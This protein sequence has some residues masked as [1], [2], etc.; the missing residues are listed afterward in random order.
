M[1]DDILEFC[2]ECG[3]E[4]PFGFEEICSLCGNEVEI[5]TDPVDELPFVVGTEIDESERCAVC[6]KWYDD[7][8]E[9]FWNYWTDFDD[10]DWLSIDDVWCFDCIL[11]RFKK[12][13][14]DFEASGLEPDTYLIWKE[15][16]DVGIDLGPKLFDIEMS[17]A[18]RRMRDIDRESMVQ[19]LDSGCEVDEAIEWMYLFDDFDEAVAWRDAGFQPDEYTT[20]R[21]HDWGC[22]PAEASSFLSQGLEDAPGKKYRDFG[23]TLQDAVFLELNGFTDYSDGDTFIGLWTS[24]G[25]SPVQMSKLKDELLEEES[26]FSELHETSE[27]HKNIG[28]RTYS[29]WKSLPGMF[30]ALKG[31]GLPITIDNLK[32]FWGLSD[33]QILK[34]IDAGGEVEHRANIV[35]QGVAVEKTSLVERLLDA[36]VDERVAASVS[37]KGLML[38]H[39]KKFKSREDIRSSVLR[40]HDIFNSNFTMDINE[41]LLWLDTGGN[42]TI[43]KQWRDYGID[44]ETASKWQKQGFYAFTAKQWMDA[45]VTSPITA[46]NRRDAGIQ[47]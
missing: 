22:T 10:P 33:K 8:D 7:E 15:A 30:E 37:R 36:G 2:K 31:V 41:A 45:G 20:G 34:V 43:V 19:W 38:K 21:W 25:L 39:L 27:R 11:K 47:P 46:K 3:M 14:P 4:F 1:A 5:E 29:F 32:K 9:W 12:D 28:D 6:K 42:G 40:L 16:L 23:F 26:D 24:S 17:N 44:V 18:I 35:R 13:N